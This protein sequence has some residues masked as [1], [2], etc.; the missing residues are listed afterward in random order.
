[1]ARELFIPHRF[2]KH[3]QQLLTQANDIIT[4]YQADHFTL[5]IRQLFYQFVARDLLPNTQKSYGRVAYLMRKGRDA[6]LVDWNAIEDRTR[7]LHR[8][9]YDEDP[10]EAILKAADT[11]IED[12][13]IGQPYRPEVW[14]EKDALLGVI[15]GV[16]AEF[17]VPYIAHRGNNSYSV[18]Y[19]AAKQFNKIKL[20]GQTPLVLHL[21]DHDPTGVDMHRDTE[22]RLARYA[23]H[24]IEVRRLGLTLQQVRRY[25]LPPNFAKETDSRYRAYVAEFG[26][27]DCWELDALAPTV[28]ADLMELNKL[29]DHKKWD[30]ARAKQDR[31]QQQLQH[32]VDNWSK[33]EAMLPKPRIRRARRDD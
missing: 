2:N 9:S 7:E 11:Y 12:P 15:E 24:K 13:W 6:G 30:V 18:V 33:V 19:Q 22:A 20:R 29:I 17:D 4:G 28:I 23:R 5:T 8:F 21:T 32:V 3:Y 10:A 27:T 14:I 25:R 16:C 26:T 31:H 1:M